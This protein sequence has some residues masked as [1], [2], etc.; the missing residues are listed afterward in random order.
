MIFHLL[1]ERGFWYHFVVA[2]WPLWSVA[3][4][5]VPHRISHFCIMC[6]HAYCDIMILL[7][8]VHSFWI[9]YH[10][11]FSQ[12]LLCMRSFAITVSSV[13]SLVCL[14]HSW[15]TSNCPKL[16]TYS[17]HRKILWPLKLLHTVFY[18]RKFR[19]SLWTNALNSE[20]SHINH[21]AVWLLCES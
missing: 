13:C 19:D 16:L 7:H 8:C 2:L 12:C 11:Y 4:L 6:L 3:A 20:N 9:A 18:R 14:S 1:S 21:C 5:D 17:L 10:R 15:I